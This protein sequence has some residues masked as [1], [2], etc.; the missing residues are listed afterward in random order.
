MTPCS[1]HEWAGMT[2]SPFSEFSGIPLVFFVISFY[3][4]A[5]MV[6]PDIYYHKLTHVGERYRLHYEKEAKHTPHSFIMA[7]NDW[8]L[9]RSLQHNFFNDVEDISESNSLHII[10][11]SYP[12]FIKFVSF[13]WFFF[14]MVRGLP[15]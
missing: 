9:F 11:H 4:R 10:Y 6:T 3:K 8:C 14:L 2:G 7:K 12:I 1:G 5:F 15:Q 13:I